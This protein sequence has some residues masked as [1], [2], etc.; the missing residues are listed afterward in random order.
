MQLN[1]ILAFSSILNIYLMFYKMLLKN[2]LS[3]ILHPSFNE[4]TWNT[5]YKVYN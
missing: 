5:L 2:L 3:I 4:K 1:I